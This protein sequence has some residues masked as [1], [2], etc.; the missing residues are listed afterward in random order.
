MPPTLWTIGHSTH[1]LGEFL[2]LL[3]SH[4]IA[5]IADV[6]RFPG[7]RRHPQFGAE[8]LPLALAEEGIGYRWFPELGGRRRPRPDSPNA[9]WKNAAF[10]GYADYMQTAEFHA[11]LDALLAFAAQRPT[12][13]MCAEAPWWRCHRAMISDALKARGVRVLHVMGAGKV[14]E[15]PYTAPARVVGGDVTYAAPGLFG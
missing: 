2:G 8:A 7:S 11:A 6:R 3:E 14:V 5:A 13:L 4:G 9:V 12:S 1:P 15:H 10:R